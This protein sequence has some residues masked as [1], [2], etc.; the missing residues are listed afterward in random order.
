MPRP[1]NRDRDDR[2]RDDRAAATILAG[3]NLE[4]SRMSPKNTATIAA[5]VVGTLLLVATVA[6]RWPSML[7]WAAFVGF[8]LG[9]VASLFGAVG[10]TR[11]RTSVAFGVYMLACAI[12]FG[13]SFSDAEVPRW[14]QLWTAALLLASVAWYVREALQGASE[15][16][17]GA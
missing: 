17:S 12:H 11:R 8:G 7:G 2:A 9:G 14:A 15:G 6:L 5:S 3:L 13:L 16:T 1:T 4:V 10:M